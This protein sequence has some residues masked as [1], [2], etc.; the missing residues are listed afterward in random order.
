M[1]PFLPVT[2]EVVGAEQLSDTQSKEILELCSAAYEESFGYYLEALPTPVHILAR[3]SGML[4]SHAA[5]VTR[6][7]QVD[8][9]EMLETAYV[10]AVATAPEYQ[11]RGYASAVMRQLITQLERYDLAA[12]SPSNV[13]FYQRLGWEAWR[14]TLAI[15]T[16]GG[17]V[18]TPGEEVMIYRL[19]RTPALD[20][21][22]RLT[23]E[24]R[25]VE[26][27]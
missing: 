20:L 5:W 13:A 25:P 9:G 16:E 1:T 24:W 3:Q 12:L 11:G 10:E 17:L 21:N 4:V 27:W 22:S 26:V 15:R 2:F 18:F 19:P 7:L 23:A 14:G 8:E 6:W